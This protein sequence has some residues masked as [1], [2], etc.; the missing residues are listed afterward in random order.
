MRPVGPE[1]GVRGGGSSQATLLARQFEGGEIGRF[2]PFRL[3]DVNVFCVVLDFS[4]C[5]SFV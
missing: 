4:V 2:S 3:G 5:V 1:E